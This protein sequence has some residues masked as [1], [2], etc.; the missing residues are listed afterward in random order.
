MQRSFRQ[1]ARVY[2]Y[3]RASSVY[4]VDEDQVAARLMVFHEAR[5]PQQTQH[6]PRREHRPFSHR[7]PPLVALSPP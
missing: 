7:T 6:F 2:R 4:R 5:L 3:Y 1:I